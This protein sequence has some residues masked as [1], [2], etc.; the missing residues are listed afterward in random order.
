MLPDGNLAE[1]RLKMC[2]HLYGKSVPLEQLLPIFTSHFNMSKKFS[3]LKSQMKE[4]SYKT[5]R[6]ENFMFLKMEENI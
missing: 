2:V 6:F 4:S 1:I 3:R 5:F